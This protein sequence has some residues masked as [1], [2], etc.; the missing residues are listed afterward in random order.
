M[1]SSSN[2]DPESTATSQS[3]GGVK[4]S[5]GFIISEDYELFTA[6]EFASIVKASPQSK[7]CKPVNRRNPVNGTYETRYALPQSHRPRPVLRV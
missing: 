1:S 4:P 5:V 6:T 7:G 3:E 2:A